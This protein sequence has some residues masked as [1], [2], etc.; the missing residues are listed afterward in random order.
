MVTAE[1]ASSGFTGRG[2]F[3]LG[4]IAGAGIEVVCWGNEIAGDEQ[5]GEMGR[6]IGGD[7][8]TEDEAGAGIIGDKTLELSG[9]AAADAS[10]E[11]SFTSDLDAL[12]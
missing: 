3:L 12:A 7:E 11:V 6:E 1:L 2:R 4:A 5:G 9:G 8:T 10:F